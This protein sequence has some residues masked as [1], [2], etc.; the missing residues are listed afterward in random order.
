MDQ[1]RFVILVADSA[2]CG[3]LP[4]AAAYGD[5]GADTIGHVARAVGGLALP[6]LGRLGLGKVLAVQGVPP[7]PAPAGF[8]GKMA[9]R[10]PGKDTTTGHWEM[11][12][13][14]LREPLALFP[15]GFPRE[16]LEPWLASTG[17]PG[18]L[19]NEVASGT[20]IIQ[21][22]GA[23]HQRT[24]KP[25]V[26][27]SADSV[28]Q[29]A[30]HTDTVPLETLY[31]WCEVARRQLDPYRVARVIARPFVGAP[32][33]YTRTYDRK[34]FSLPAPAPTV[35]Q[36]LAAAGVPVVGVGKIPDIY[37]RQGISREVHTAGNADGLARTEALLGE[38][39]Q[40][41]LFVNLVDFDMLYGHR[42]D[43][44][45]YARALEELDRALPRLLARLR[46]GDVLAITADHGC[47]PTHAGTDHTREHVPLLVHAGGRGG[48]LG[49]RGS[50]SD[51]GATCAGL[52]GVP[53]QVGTSFLAQLTATRS[54]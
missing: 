19:G 49:V 11:M 14:V 24:G 40:G 45:G 17:A 34:D 3:A 15:R 42:R 46:P 37:D 35:L 33:A 27:T 44:K 54:P 25:I 29:V 13:V 7:D 39:E 5:A 12:G 21:R 53:A 43:V 41:L 28:F 2:G 6:N 9:E 26:Y 1:R 30:A 8:W 51:L 47:D 52:F 10:S 50:F 32:G 23:E 4:D 20:E 36:A 16:I 31:R 48:P 22:L 38:L 18:V